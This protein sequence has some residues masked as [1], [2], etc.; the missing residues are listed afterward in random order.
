M[1]EDVRK[2]RAYDL[3]TL[4]RLI[5]GCNRRFNGM[6]NGPA[7]SRTRSNCVPEPALSIIPRFF[8]L[9]FFFLFCSPSL[10][11]KPEDRSNHSVSAIIIYLRWRRKEPIKDEKKKK[12]IERLA[13]HEIF[14]KLAALTIG[15]VG[16]C[17][18]VKN[19]RQIVPSLMF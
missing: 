18:R 8:L 9:S 17:C 15:P 1:D 10:E 11:N 12:M 2:K 4:F 3:S 5:Y 7:L 14:N 16:R 13:L 6:A 19:G